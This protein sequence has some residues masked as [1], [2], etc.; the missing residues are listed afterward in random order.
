MTLTRFIVILGMVLTLSGCG[1]RDR[2]FGGET[3][4]VPLPYRAK[5]S[6]GD[7]QRNFNVRVSRAGGATVAQVRE[8]A[9]FQ[10]TRYCLTSY[11]GSDTRWQ[12]NQS[13]GEWAFTRD[14]QDMIFSGRCVAR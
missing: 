13:T 9:R 5:L 11:G 14:G 10:A 7:D 6:K 4:D 12:I 3:S 8:S 2:L 1:I